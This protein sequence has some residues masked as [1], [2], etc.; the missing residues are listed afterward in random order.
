LVPGDATM[1]ETAYVLPATA[2]HVLT[3]RMTGSGVPRACPFCP[4]KS[5]VY[6][7]R[8]RKGIMYLG[9]EVPDS[10]L[11]LD[12]APPTS[13]PRCAKPGAIEGKRE[14]SG[15]SK[16]SPAQAK[17]TTGSEFQSSRTRWCG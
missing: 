6:L 12:G 16:R 2:H 7:F 10:T 13:S 9:A 5:D 3:R 4:A 1:V 8:Y 11:D 17:D 15:H 14:I